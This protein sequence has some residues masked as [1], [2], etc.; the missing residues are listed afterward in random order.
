MK[1]LKSI[2]ILSFVVGWT[3]I[4]VAEA[5]DEPASKSLFRDADLE[6]RIFQLQNIELYEAQEVLSRIYNTRHI[7]AIEG[8]NSLVVRDTAAVLDQIA[9][10]FK[11][12]EEQPQNGP[13]PRDTARVIS[14]G[15][16]DPDEIA[17]MLNSMYH[18]TNIRADFDSRQIV[19]KGDNAEE[20]M[21]IAGM[22]AQL[23]VQVVHGPKRARGKTFSIT[24]DFI[25][26]TVGA[27]V[28][29]DLPENLKG[30][31]AA[32]RKQGLGNLSVYGH[33]MVRSQ[34]GEEFETKGV[35]RSGQPSVPASYV[36]LQGTADITGDSAEIRIESQLNL[37]IP[38]KIVDNAG[39]TH[40]SYHLEDFGLNTTTTVQ[41]GDFLVLGA[42]PA[43]TE[44]SDTILMV[45]H[46]TAD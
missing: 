26:A 11:Q 43:S 16:R 45:I 42:M 31:G 12:M 15:S 44:D 29:G 25:S 27:K 7:A 20:I 14:L 8:S 41:L 38:Q 3:T 1:V 28:D 24:A 19:L 36:G 22:I 23:D 32:L 35:V 5:Q 37:P 17:D 46:I 40:T 33:L 34:E 30:V 18:N 10:L 13:S 2:L 21:E 39:K 4:G 9:D 6:T